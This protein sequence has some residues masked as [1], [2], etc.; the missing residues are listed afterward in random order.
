MTRWT[1]TLILTAVLASTV[2]H[3]QTD[4]SSQ[5][6]ISSISSF[7]NHDY[8]KMGDTIFYEH[9]PTTTTK[10]IVKSGQLKK[11]IQCDCNSGC[12]TTV[13][14]RKNNCRIKRKCR[15]KFAMNNVPCF[16]SPD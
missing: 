11:E 4:T 5:K 9:S 15:A 16:C 2:A 1:I 3:G 8:S 13:I 12:I 10:F 6:T 7:V 14:Y